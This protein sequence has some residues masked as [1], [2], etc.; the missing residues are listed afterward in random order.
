MLCRLY[1]FYAGKKGTLSG[2]SQKPLREQKEARSS[3]DYPLSLRLVAI[4]I[5]AIRARRKDFIASGLR[6]LRRGYSR[7]P[8]NFFPPSRDLKS[9]HLPYKAWNNSNATACY[10]Y[11][12]SR[13]SRGNKVGKRKGG[14]KK[15]KKTG[16]REFFRKFHRSRLRRTWRLNLHP[17]AGERRA[18]FADQIEQGE[19]IGATTMPHGRNG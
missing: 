5:R 6:R 19:I 8:Y 10:I 7:L 1:L 4:C 3:Y 12:G 16:T 18:T 14:K 2:V 11:K 13:F 9:L 15:E 17:T